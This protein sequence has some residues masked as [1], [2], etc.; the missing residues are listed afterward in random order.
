MTWGLA[1]SDEPA[2]KAVPL[3]SQPVQFKPE[4][5]QTLRVT[6]HGD[7]LKVDVAGATVKAKD[8]I[9]AQPKERMHLI[10][11]DGEV[12]LRRLVVVE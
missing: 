2:D 4:D 12:G 10:A 1:V 11:F 5:W 9:F 7:E 3:A 6:F 8:A